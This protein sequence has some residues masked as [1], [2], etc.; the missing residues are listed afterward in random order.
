[1]ARRDGTETRTDSSDHRDWLDRDQP[2]D[3]VDINELPD[4]WADAIT[5]FREHDL[6][7]Y[8]PPRFSDGV[9]VP[10]V[11]SRLESAYDAEIRFIGVGVQYGDA[12]SVYADGDV[13]TTVDRE[14]T[15]DAYTRYEMTS[16]EF[17]RV[18]RD[19]LEGEDASN[20]S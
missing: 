6:R 5:E 14:R 8:S 15:A 4:W 12:W 2:Y 16:G 13:V 18:V 19:H 7:P 3:G 1:M 17:E 20:L 9:L 10:P 11:V